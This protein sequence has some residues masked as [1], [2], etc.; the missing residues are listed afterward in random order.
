MLSRQYTT[1]NAQTTLPRC[2]LNVAKTGFLTTRLSSSHL[3]HEIKNINQGNCMK[4][5]EY[6]CHELHHSSI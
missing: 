6:P 5:Y 3:V 2:C 1:V 4:V